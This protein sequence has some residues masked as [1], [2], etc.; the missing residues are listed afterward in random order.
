MKRLLALLS[1][2]ALPVFG[3]AIATTPNGIVV[4]H[5]RVI[6]LI[7]D[8]GAKIWKSNGVDLPTKIITTTDRAAVIDSLSNEVR[9]VDL[10]SGAGTTVKTGDTPIDGAFVGRDLFVLE[11]DS[12]SLSRIS[13]DGRATSVS[14]AADP[15]FLRAAGGRLYVYSRR[16][17]VFQEIDPARLTLTR[18]LNVSP[19]A[20]DM[21]V[22][23]RNAYLLYP[24][25]AKI[26]A[27]ELRTMKES[28]EIPV[29]AVPVDLALAGGANAVSARTLAVADPSAKR[30]WITEGSQSVSQ[31]VARGFLRGLLGLGLYS[32]RSSEFPTGVDRVIAAGRR[33]IAYD[34]SSG[35]LYRVTKSK[36]DVVAKGVDPASFAMRGDTLFFWQNGQLFSAK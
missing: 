20:S 31:A 24:R 33:W 14:V 29:G 32:N 19:F 23:A 13:V 7:D 2:M 3:D 16:D 10:R 17:G 15:A 22:D 36:A 30:V 34:S 9:V 4:A 28:G 26:R 18:T 21:E 6:E 8:R 27:I 5:D 1:V 35:T 25:A 12:G 11:R